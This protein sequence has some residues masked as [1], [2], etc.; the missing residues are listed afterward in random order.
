M[1]DYQTSN[2]LQIISIEAGAAL[3][4]ANRFVKMSS[5]KAVVCGAN[6]QAIGVLQ[7]AVLAG[8]TASIITA[9]IALVYVGSGGVTENTHV[10]SDATGKAIAVAAITATAT[11]GNVTSV[12]T[13]GDA[14]IPAGA[15]PVTSDSATPTLEITQ[16]TI[17]NTVTQPTITMA[18]GSPAVKVLGIALDSVL[19]NGYARIKLI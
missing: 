12:A 13:L 16:P 19:E 11:S 2:P 1:A 6:G 10:T 15:T 9:G 18:G 5:G 14:V 8:Q 4:N 17:T 7:S 3:A